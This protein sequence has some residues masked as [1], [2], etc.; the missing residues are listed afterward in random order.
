MKKLFFLAISLILFF[1]LGCFTSKTLDYAGNPR[2]HR[3]L[4]FKESYIDKNNN[5][6]VNFETKIGKN[7]R[8]KQYHIKLNLDS[9][10][11]Y[12]N[13]DDST[14]VYIL[15]SVICQKLRIKNAFYHLDGKEARWSITLLNNIIAKGNYK[16]INI[17]VT[18]TK[19]RFKDQGEQ[20]IA[21]VYN[22]QF[23]F[24]KRNFDHCEIS[25]SIEGSWIDRQ[26]RYCLTPLGIVADIVTSPIQ[27]IAIIFYLIKF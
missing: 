14:S 21:F 8:S 16:P 15:D 22:S 12:V 19:D 5:L 11:N 3:P 24:D 17:A 20:N 4:K 23:E 10:Y 25:F 2:L 27:M 1:T 13:Y 18:L 9:T 7:R 26:W 6:I